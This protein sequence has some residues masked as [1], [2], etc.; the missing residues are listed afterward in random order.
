[1]IMRKYI[2]KMSRLI[3]L[4]GRVLDLLLRLLLHKRNK[5]GILEEDGQKWLKRGRNLDAGLGLVV[6]QDGA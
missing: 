3:C 5:G 6:L 4:L 2:R 1:M